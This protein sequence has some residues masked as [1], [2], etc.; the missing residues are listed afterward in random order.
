M[1]CPRT[2]LRY[3]AFRR[4]GFTPAAYAALG[5]ALAFRHE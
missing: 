1:G 2:P 3:G 5:S 4:E